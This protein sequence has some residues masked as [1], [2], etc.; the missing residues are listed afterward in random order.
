M[1]NGIGDMK[2]LLRLDLNEVCDR[3]HNREKLTQKPDFKHENPKRSGQ[4]LRNINHSRG[5]HIST[6]VPQ[7]PSG[8][9]SFPP[10]RFQGPA[11]GP[12]GVATVVIL[13]E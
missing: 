2:L 1:L 7:G 9:Q 5:T 4:G 13:M 8:L 6:C 10:F 11:V 12:W 3:K